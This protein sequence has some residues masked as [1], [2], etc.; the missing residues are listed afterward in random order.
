MSLEFLQ[1]HWALA[2]AG[3][4][5]LA[6]LLLLGRHLVLATRGAQL[7]ARVRELRETEKA[8]VKT[9]KAV[10]KST[11]KLERLR[12]KA[13]SVRPR[14]IDEEQGKLEDAKALQKILNDKVLVSEN[15]V[16]RVIYEEFPPTEHDRLRKKYLPQ[17]IED[18]RPF[19]F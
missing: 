3:L 7:N 14:L 9:A 16:R 19:S 5:G 4:I 10:A 1:Q 12:R 15:H 17:D 8:V 13:D 2:A 11:K 6:V 18:G